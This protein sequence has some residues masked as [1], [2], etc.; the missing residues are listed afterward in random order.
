MLSGMKRDYYSDCINGRDQPTT[1]CAPASAAS[2]SFPYTIT[3]AFIN[4]AEAA[5]DEVLRPCIDDPLILAHRK[6]RI[7]DIIQ[8]VPGADRRQ[9]WFNRISSKQADFVICLGQRPI[10]VIEI[11]DRSH[12]SAKRRER[13]AFV[14]AAYATARLPSLH[15]GAANTYDAEKISRFIESTAYDASAPG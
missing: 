10:G 9:Y 2:E 13:D 1:D 5:F 8:V 11:D 4:A 6:V 3:P 14:D 7:A 12:N 15:V